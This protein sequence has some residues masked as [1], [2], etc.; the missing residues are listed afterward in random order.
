MRGTNIV[1]VHRLCGLPGILLGVLTASLGMV[2]M[3]NPS[4]PAALTTIALG[5]TLAIVGFSELVLALASV[6]PGTFSMRMLVGV[7]HGLTGGVVIASASGETDGLTF[8]VGV[9]LT[10]RGVVAGVVAF[11]VHGIPGWRW[12]LADAMA[13]FVVGGLILL[14]WPSSTDWTLGTLVGV[15]L[16][17]TGASRAFF[18]AK[19]RDLHLARSDA[20]QGSRREPSG[21][22]RTVGRDPP[23]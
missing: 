14:E 9:M 12:V 17:V 20:M 7:L 5:W 2:L 8:F 23:P 15:S 19:L 1:D 11:Q 22:L 10:V 6:S 21:R 16:L 4:A 18:A 13:S 3:G